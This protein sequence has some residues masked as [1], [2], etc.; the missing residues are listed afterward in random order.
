MTNLHDYIEGKRDGKNAHNLEK[1]SMTDPF[2][3][4]AID[5]FDTVDDNHIERLK[6]IQDQISNKK[7]Q[8]TYANSNNWSK[9]AAAA[10]ALLII[11]GGKKYI[12][13]KYDADNVQTSNVAQAPLDL[14]VPEIFYEENIAIIATKNTEFTKGLRITFHNSK[15]A[16]STEE[17]ETPTTK[18]NSTKIEPIEIYTPFQPEN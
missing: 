11:V 14:Y 12:L 3:N 1:E 15:N 8:S 18:I 7:R 16:E 2:L 6:I 17:I 9:I 10:A 13:D 4:E 5:G